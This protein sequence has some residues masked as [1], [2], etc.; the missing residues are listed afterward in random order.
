[1]GMGKFCC[2]GGRGTS[3]KNRNLDYNLLVADEKTPQLAQT[4]RP[5]EI[6]GI[7]SGTSI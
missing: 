7:K 1:M 3:N 5:Q 2:A 4:E 6:A